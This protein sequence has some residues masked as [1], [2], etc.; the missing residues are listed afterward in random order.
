MQSPEA[1]YLAALLADLKSETEFSQGRKLQSIFFGGGTPSLMSGATIARIIEAAEQQIGF[2]DNIEITLEANPGT[3]EQQRFKDYRLAGVNR[4]SLGAQSFDDGQLK[5]LGRIHQADEIVRAVEMAKQAGFQ[6]FNI[7]LMFALPDQ[8]VEAACQDLQRAI[9]LQ[10]THLSWYQLTI[11][12]NTV[13]Y[14]RPPANLPDEDSQF[15][16]FQA[17]Q[18]L[19]QAQGYLQY[20]TSAYALAGYACRHNVNYW[21]FGDYLGIGAG[22]HG[23]FTSHIHNQIKIGRRQKIRTPEHY[24]RSVDPCSHKQ[25]LTP[26]ELRVEFM[27]NALRLRQ[28]VPAGLFTARTGL[29]WSGIEPTILQLVKEGLLEANP[30]RLQPTEKGALFLNDVIARFM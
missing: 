30:S 26:P 2:A 7:D 22:A 25:E 15:D 27:L 3:A 11:E 16:I 10:P 13:F 20:E 9:S 24:L 23:K 21:D 29:P 18:Q 14:R 28:G 17:G 8:T 12:P 5:K 6:N 1:D 19:L 4:I